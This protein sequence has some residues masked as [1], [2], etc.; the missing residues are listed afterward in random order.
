[1]S[2]STDRLLS[3]MARLRD[4]EGGCPWDLEQDL[5][6]LRPYVIEEAYEVVEAIDGGSP[7]ALKEEL[8]DLLLQIVF[9]S[10]VAEEKGWFSFEDVA[11][12]ISDKMV[13]R[14]PHV[15]GDREVASAGEVLKNWEQIKA[16]E[17]KGRKGTL[18]G[19]PPALP[20]LLKAQ[21]TGEKAAAV[22]FDWQDAVGVQAKLDE[23][24]AELR[25][26][27]AEGDAAAIEHEL[28]DLLFALT[29]LARHIS[30]DAES[31]LQSAV[32]RF[33]S[34][35]G[36]VESIAREKSLT[37]NELDDVALDDLWE[38]AK[39]RLGAAS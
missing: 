12:R 8:G 13:E 26:A 38:A 34:R 24:A 32:R 36:V 5:S 9:Q 14:H 31:A 22:G 17:R 3:I 33:A 37:L 10:R 20:A 2:A 29:S 28:G 11:E 15:F 27:M 19:V 21:R 23:E 18:S 1:M 39:A 25:E 6:T 30:V 7:G 4:P 16:K 35:F